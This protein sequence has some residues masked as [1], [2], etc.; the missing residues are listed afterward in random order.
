MTKDNLVTAPV[1]TTLAAGAG[2]PEQA[3]R[4]E[5]LPD[6]GRQIAILQRTHH[7]QGHR[8][9]DEIP[10]LLHRT[11]TADFS[12]A[13]AIGV[14]ADVLEQSQSASGRSSARTSLVL[15]SAHGHSRKNH[16]RRVVAQ[17]EIR[18]SRKRRPSSRATSRPPRQPRT[19]ISRRRR[20][21]QGRYRSGLHLHD[22]CSGRHR[23]SADHSHLATLLQ[24]L[25]ASG[26]PVI[27]D[28][29]IKLLRRHRQGHRCR[30][31]RAS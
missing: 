27:A 28:G 20:R 6:R 12:A 15:D 17:S 14:T 13:A 7:H 21:R 5:K 25:Q 11:R 1:G 23:R 9:G 30:R 19:I 16:H 3:H 26:V 10:A 2:N 24:R 29:G 22:P 18:V 31:Q 4:I 8:K